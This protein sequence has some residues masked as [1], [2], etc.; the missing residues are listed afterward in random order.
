MKSLNY[1]SLHFMYLFKAKISSLYSFVCQTSAYLKR[2]LTGPAPDFFKRRY[3]INKRFSNN[4]AWIETGTFTGKTTAYLSKYSDYAVTIEPEI[5]LYN[6]AKSRIKSRKILFLN[7]TSE[8]KLQEAID[9][10][11]SKRFKTINFWL[12][13]HFSSGTTYKGEQVCPLLTELNIIQK[14][15]ESKNLIDVES[16]IYIDDL[17]LFCDASEPKIREAEGY[18][19]LKEVLTHPIVKH[20]KITINID[21]LL[22][23]ISL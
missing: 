19:D 8:S 7:G 16:N 9:K 13:G 20:S 11:I 6:K 18:P 23:Q 3:L 21:I 1:L 22:V 2:G 14:N 10:V 5:N 4:V 15:I 12:D 17:R